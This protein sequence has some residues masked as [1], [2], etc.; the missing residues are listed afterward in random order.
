MGDGCLFK[1]VSCFHISLRMRDC[2]QTL[3]LFHWILSQVT[4]TDLTENASEVDT[5]V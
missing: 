5:G 4:I 1:D 2:A 3:S